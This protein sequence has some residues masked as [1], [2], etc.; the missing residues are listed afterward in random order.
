MTTNGQN[1]KVI[2]VPFLTGKRLFTG[3]Q[4]KTEEID[5]GNLEKMGPMIEKVRVQFDGADFTTNFQVRF[6]F[7]WSVS[8]RIYSTDIEILPNQTSEGQVIGAWYDTGSNFGLNM[9]YYVEY[10]NETGTANETGRV[11]AWLEVVLKS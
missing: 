8:G 7:K 2:V 9:K 1:K 10:S 3:G 4:V 6:L 11:S 5:V